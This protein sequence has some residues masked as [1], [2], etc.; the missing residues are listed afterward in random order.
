MLQVHCI[1]SFLLYVDFRNDAGIVKVLTDDSEQ[2]EYEMLRRTPRRV[3][4]GGEVVKMRTPDSDSNEAARNKE[5]IHEEKAENQTARSFI[6][7]AVASNEKSNSEPNSPR[8][9]NKKS[10]TK[11][12]YRSSPNLQHVFGPKV[13]TSRIPRRNDSFKSTIKITINETSTNDNSPQNKHINEA[14]KSEKSITTNQKQTQSNKTSSKLANSDSLACETKTKYLPKP[15][16]NQIEVLHNL[17]RSPERRNSEKDEPN[18]K[19]TREEAV[20]P[21][22]SSDV[23]PK[24]T[25]AIKKN[26]NP[27]TQ[28]NNSQATYNSFWVCGSELEDSHA[29]MNAL[30]SISS[31]SGGVKSGYDRQMHPVG[32]ID[33]N[34][35]ADIYSKVRYLC[36]FL[37]I[38][39]AVQLL[40]SSINK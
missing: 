27:H 15:V 30:P 34:I 6:P 36:L 38:N 33:E 14:K 8:R 3:R 11:V 19:E 29:D 9:E 28:N 26:E 20:N 7:V 32:L 12:V 35:I 40:N 13:N 4:F 24:Q 2:D 22:A 25:D 31:Q 21:T 10:K 1:N 23:K 5:K 16:H 17:T 18:K 37:Y 39:C